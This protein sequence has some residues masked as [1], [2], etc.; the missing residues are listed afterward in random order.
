MFKKSQAAL[1]FLTTYAWAFLI[2]LIMIGA[3]AYFGVLNP[4]R[5][6]PERC[7]FGAELGCDKDRVIANTA[8]KVTFEL[9]NSVGEAISVNAVRV[10]SD[11]AAFTVN[12]PATGYTNPWRPG[13]RMTLTTGNCGTLTAD[14]KTKFTV[15]IDYYVTSAGSSYGKT[16]YG[17]IY[18]AVQ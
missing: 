9:V 14:E 15:D 4:S 6:L 5:L 2:I 18:T 17:E 10:N 7:N 3:L 8:G 11:V 1:E 16:V 13:E 12:C